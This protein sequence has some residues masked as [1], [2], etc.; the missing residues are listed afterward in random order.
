MP[1]FAEFSN[2]DHA[3]IGASAKKWAL[4]PIRARSKFENSANTGIYRR[5]TLASQ[6]TVRADVTYFADFSCSVSRSASAREHSILSVCSS[7]FFLQRKQNSWLNHKSPFTAHAIPERV[8]GEFEPRYVEQNRISL[9]LALVFSVIYYGLSNSVNTPLSPTVFFALLS[10]N[11]PPSF[12]TLLRSKQT[13]ANISQDQNL[14]MSSS[15]YLELI[16]TTPVNSAFRA[17]WLVPLSR[18]IKYYSPPGGF[19]RK[20][21]RANPILS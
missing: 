4:G 2:F 10:S 9:G 11:Q 18:D 7:F 5:E 21:W 17:I 1:V 19:R 20:K 14:A 8:S 15:R 16:Y 13:L 12:R 6:A 3:R